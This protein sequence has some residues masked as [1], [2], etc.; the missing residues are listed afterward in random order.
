[1]HQVAEHGPGPDHRYSF[2]NVAGAAR[3]VGDRT[4]HF[5]GRSVVPDNAGSVGHNDEV[6][7]SDE[8]DAEG[9]EGS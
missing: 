3:L 9:G 7:D 6:V 8:P 2:V 4:A 1:M 5:R